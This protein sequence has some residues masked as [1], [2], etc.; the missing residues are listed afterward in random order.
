MYK[1]PSIFVF[2]YSFQ[3]Q[4]VSLHNQEHLQDFEIKK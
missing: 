2:E 4:S 1:K 3:K